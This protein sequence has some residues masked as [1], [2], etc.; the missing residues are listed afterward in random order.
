M[1]DFDP[2]NPHAMFA[3]IDEHLK[4]QDKAADIR[5]DAVETKLTSIETQAIKT[6]GRVTELEAEKWRQRGVV[7]AIAL[8]FGA[9]SW[10]LPF[11]WPLIHK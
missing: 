3:R 11:L 9:L 10:I 5:H 7:T 4:A 2:N 6:N 1:E 8:I